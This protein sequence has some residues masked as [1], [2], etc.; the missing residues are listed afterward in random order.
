MSISGM[1]RTSASG[2]TAQSMRLG[3][4]SDNIANASTHGYKRAFTEFST[5]VLE[6]GSGAYVPGSV[7]TTVRYGISQQGSFDYTSSKTDLGVSGTGFM[8]VGDGTG[9]SYLT[10]AGNFV[11]DDQ[12]YLVNAA[13]FKLQGYPIVNGQVS[14]SANGTAGI[15][16]VN[17]GTL[18]L[19]ATPSTEGTFHV[20]LPEEAVAPAGNTAGDNQADS[21]YNAKT[22]ITAI[23]N[24]GSEVVLDVYY[25]KT[26]NANEWQMAVYARADANSA[27][28]PFPYANAAIATE[29]LTFDPANGGKLD[30]ALPS[31]TE[32]TI[33]VPGGQ[34]LVLDFSQSTELA[35]DFQVISPEV[36]GNTP[37]S[38]ESVE[39][40]TDG[41]LYAVYGN[42]TRIGMYQIPLATVPS[43]DNLTPLAGNVYAVSD[44]SG[45]L[46]VGF[47]GVGQFGELRTSQLEKSTVDTASELTT[48]IESQFAFTANSKVFQTGGELM[49]VIVNL[50]R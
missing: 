26:G 18:A 10:R 39:F 3:T 1:M 35:D 41:T 20:N 25:W 8:L 11:K 24:V 36:N 37:S 50:K 16:E 15:Q 44:A 7:D 48:M 21:E 13:G 22:S 4:V 45:N 28:Q 27:T 23:D 31:P 46:Q 14:A 2:M 29:T 42:G 34:D 47:P 33:P 9:A 30:A 12:G 5:M 17:V 49:E 32:I 43:P 6:S 19:T 40:G 38:V